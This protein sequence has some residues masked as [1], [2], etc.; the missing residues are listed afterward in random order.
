MDMMLAVI[1]GAVACFLYIA[2]FDRKNLFRN[3]RRAG[4]IK[5]RS[6]TRN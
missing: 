1:F 6:G 4:V 5:E 2:I 3:L